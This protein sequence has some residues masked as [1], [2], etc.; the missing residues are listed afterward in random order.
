MHPGSW[1]GVDA[2]DGESMKAHTGGV[3]DQ[4]MRDWWLLV[5]A[6]VLIIQGDAPIGSE[7]VTTVTHMIR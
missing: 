4:S 2:S 1:E 7:K 3:M 5:A 6:D